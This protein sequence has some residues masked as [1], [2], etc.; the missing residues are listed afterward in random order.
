MKYLFKLLLALALPL[1]IANKALAIELPPHSPVPGGVALVTLPASAG[2]P[3]V[4]YRDR[5]AMVVKQDGQWLAVVG[6]PLAAKAGQ[7]SL[8]VKNSQG[9]QHKVSFTIRDKSYQ[10]QYITLKNKRM[11]NPEKRDMT[12]IG[13]EQK[14]IR[15]AFANWDDVQLPTL[16]LALP[17]TA[18]VS[19]PFGLRRFF[20]RQPRKPHSGLDLAAAEGTPVVA[21]AT[22][23]VTETGDFFFNGNT[24]FVDHGQ[25]LVTM[26]CHLSRIDV[27][28]GQRV[29]TGDVIGAVG[30]TGRVTG[31]HL[32]WSVSLNNTRVDPALFLDSSTST[33]ASP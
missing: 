1:L 28:P 5:R 20:N 23:R 9:K 11:V 21:P 4:H 2:A 16:R 6:I 32:H 18:P 24:V 8:T 7:A 31:A 15:K 10:S 30:K 22:G 14:R 29:K 25:G 13:R 26:Y 12:R 17:V 27:Q 33:N 19:S 3:V